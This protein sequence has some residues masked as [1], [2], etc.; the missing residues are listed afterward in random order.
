MVFVGQKIVGIVGEGSLDERRRLFFMACFKGQT[1][2]LRFRFGVFRTKFK[3]LGERRSGAFGLAHLFVD[4]SK[5]QTRTYTSLI[6]LET[7]LVSFDRV[8]PLTLSGKK[9]GQ[10]LSKGGIIRMS[11]S[12]NREHG[13]SLLVV[14]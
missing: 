10:S 12:G 2:K 14:A 4:P 6:K 9:I 5:R 1:A 13:A 8:V 7:L 3:D 11:S